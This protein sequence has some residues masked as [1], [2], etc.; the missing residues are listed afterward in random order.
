MEKEKFYDNGPFGLQSGTWNYQYLFL[1][2][3][4]FFSAKPFRLLAFC[5]LAIWSI[6][7]FVNLPF[8][9]LAIQS[10]CHLVNLLFCQIAI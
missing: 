10:T 5:L 2:F 1:F 4:L 9:Q 3:I 6:C 8:C 7:H